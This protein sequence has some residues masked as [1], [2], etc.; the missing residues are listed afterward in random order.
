MKADAILLDLQ[1]MMENPWISQDLNIA[2]ILIH[3]GKGNYVNTVII[4][5]KVIMR[6]REFLNIDIE[7]LYKEVRSQAEKGKGREQQKYAEN[8]QKIKPYYHRYYQDWPGKP[9]LS[10][11][12]I[13]NSKI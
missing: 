2:E 10:P 12:Y 11:F 8:L 4:G 7:K 5:G 13:M 1:E 6:D 9:N 3:R